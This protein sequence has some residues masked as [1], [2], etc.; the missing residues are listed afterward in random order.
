M[1][2]AS[3]RGLGLRS[4]L[5]REEVGVGGGILTEARRTYDAPQILDK[6]IILRYKTTHTRTVILAHRLGT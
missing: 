5:V 4:N 1:P 6:T 2:N 3:S